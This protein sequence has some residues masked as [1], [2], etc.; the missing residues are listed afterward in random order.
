MKIIYIKN[1]D[2]SFIRLDEEI[3]TKNFNT[4]VLTL[5]TSDRYTYFCQLFKLIF[6]LI[7]RM[8]VISV[9]FTRFADWH[10]A[11][12]A[13]FCRL[14]RKKL[15]VVVGGYDVSCLPEYQYGVYYRKTRGRW[16]KYA[17]RSASLVLPN[18]PSLI[19]NTNNYV[20]GK[21]RKAGLNIFIPG[22]KGKIKVVYNGYHTDFW[23]PRNE[24]KQKNL[25]IMVSYI[26]NQRSFFIKGVND[27]IEAASGMP[28]IKFK[29]IGAENRQ[30]EEWCGKLPENLE[31]MTSLDRTKLL[32]EYQKAKVFCLL[33]L[34][35]G[36][37]NV[38]CEAMLCSCIP[39]VSDV[40]FNAQLV[41]DSGFVVPWKDITIIKDTIRKAVESGEEMGMMARKRIAENYPFERREDELVKALSDI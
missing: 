19:E 24:L 35:E 31:L 26:I 17:L 20:R 21:S 1:G 30:I 23:V 38:L 15:V 40:N 41:S 10:T 33:S 27:F 32:L 14:Y 5:K 8:P 4:C 9:A 28:D 22:L 39:V 36:M 13:F 11:I 6:V 25:V 34:S 12:I 18:N 7:I 16:A 3:L 37:P 29:L 2:S